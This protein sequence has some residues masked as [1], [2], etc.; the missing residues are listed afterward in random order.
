MIGKNPVMKSP[1]VGSPARNRGMSPV[2]T[3]PAEFVYSPKRNHGPELRMW[4]R[5]S[6]MSNRLAVPYTK[7][8][9][10][11]FS[12]TQSDRLVRPASN[13]GYTSP[14]STER[15][16]AARAAIIGTKRRPP[17]KAR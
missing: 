9:M 15:T 11:L 16:I 8:P 13:A 4:C 3:V 1:A 14:M 5:P 2:T 17:K 12:A 7:P 10:T 6:G